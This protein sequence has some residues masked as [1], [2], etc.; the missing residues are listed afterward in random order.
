[1]TKSSYRIRTIASKTIKVQRGN[2]HLAEPLLLLSGRRITAKFSAE[3]CA[4]VMEDKTI[5]AWWQILAWQRQILEV[6]GAH[7]KH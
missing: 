3:E 1:M 6:R 7:N 5:P 2:G 4:Q